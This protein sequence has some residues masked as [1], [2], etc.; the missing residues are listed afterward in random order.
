MKRK[1][2]SLY[3]VLERIGVGLRDLRKR[4][5]YDT[6]KDFADENDLPFV[7]YWKIEKGKSNLT[8]KTLVKVLAVHRLTVE[9]F[10]CLLEDYTQTKKTLLHRRS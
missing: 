4:L 7:Q 1:S 6:I 10:F 8:M 5:G 2:K 3:T 9:E